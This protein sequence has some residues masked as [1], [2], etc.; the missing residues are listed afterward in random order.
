MSAD[1]RIQAGG[2]LGKRPRPRTL[3]LF[4]IVGQVFNPLVDTFEGS[5]LVELHPRVDIIEKPDHWE[6]KADVPGIPQEKL[7]LSIDRGILTLSGSR[8]EA[9]EE[10]DPKTHYRRIER[11]FGSFQR[12]FTLPENIDETK[13][14][15]HLDHGVLEI[16]IPKKAPESLKREIPISTAP[17]AASTSRL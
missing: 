15:A 1:R 14:S 3:D 4:D 7:E 10:E 11:S 17:S 16:R 9:T 5:K 13:L 8:S 2:N 6:V 12:S